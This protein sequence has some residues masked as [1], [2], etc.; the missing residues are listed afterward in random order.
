MR[1]HQ[2]T[3]LAFSP[4][5]VALPFVEGYFSTYPRGAIPVNSQDPY[6]PRQDL[7]GVENRIYDDADV[8]QPMDER[9]SRV[10]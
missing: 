3:S 6:L 2:L 7:D 10:I 1:H 5:N 8:M 4:R 9:Q